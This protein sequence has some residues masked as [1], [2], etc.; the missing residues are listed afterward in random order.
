MHITR[1]LLQHAKRKKSWE[2]LGVHRGASKQEVRKA[3]LKSAKKLHPDMGGDPTRFIELQ[4]AFEEIFL[5]QKLEQEIKN[6]PSPGSK[7]ARKEY[8]ESVRKQE[9]NVNKKRRPGVRTKMKN[10]FT[11]LNKTVEKTPSF[12]RW[13]IRGSLGFVTD[14]FAV[15]LLVVA[16]C[17]FI[18][19]ANLPTEMFFSNLSLVSHRL[20]AFI[21]EKDDLRIGDAE[22]A[23]AASEQ[24]DYDDLV[25]QYKL[26]CEAAKQAFEEE[27]R[28]EEEA[29]QKL[30][31]ENA[32]I[33]TDEKLSTEY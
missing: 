17:V 25:A 12:I 29:E 20:E 3:Y 33:P 4:K 23:F 30:A 6:R 7:K 5:E 31:M 14:V 16:A 18:V 10:A 24:D 11:D 19:M 13:V 15:L 28:E 22:A 21:S 27:F 1:L 8:T 9:E 2:V 26:K 32:N